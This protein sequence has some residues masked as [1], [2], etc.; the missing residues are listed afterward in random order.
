[1]NLLGRKQL[2]PDVRAFTGNDQLIRLEIGYIVFVLDHSEAIDLAAQLVAVVDRQ[3][4][5]IAGDGRR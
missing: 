4:E 2:R 5:G 1:M 3:R